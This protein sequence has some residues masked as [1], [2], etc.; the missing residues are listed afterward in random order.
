MNYTV[1]RIWEGQTCV[2][3]AGGPSLKKQDLSALTSTH[4]W[5]KVIAINDS[6]KLR[7]YANVLYFVDA[8]WW[9]RQM[10]MNEF[11]VDGQVRFHDAIYKCNWIKGGAGFQDHPQIKQIAFTGQVGLE[12]NPQALRHGS[13]SGYSAVNLA[14]LFGAKRIV[15]LGYDMKVQGERSHWHDRVD[16]MPASYFQNVLQNEFLPLVSYLVEP[17][18]KA[19]VEVINATPDSA[20]TLW[21][22]MTLEQALQPVSCP[23]ARLPGSAEEPPVAVAASG[24]GRSRQ[25]SQLQAKE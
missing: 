8:A 4:P 25:E 19:G 10:D 3:L 9:Q 16:N 7:P 1:P 2:I 17:L 13:N 24:R 20:L 15:L 22:S 18:R 6:W 12:E 21:P 14:Y 23:A 5:P 11:S